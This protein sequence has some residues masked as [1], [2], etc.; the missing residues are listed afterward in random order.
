MCG[1]QLQMICSHPDIWSGRDVGGEL[2]KVI[3]SFKDDAFSELGEIN[4]L[5]RSVK[6]VFLS[7]LLP[8]LINEKHSLLIFS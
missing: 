8:E 5:D 7:D 4:E 3:N 2:N 6:F 1:Q